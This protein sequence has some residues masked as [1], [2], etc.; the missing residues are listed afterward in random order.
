ME[1]AENVGEGVVSVLG[2]DDSHFQDVLDGMTEE[3]MN[4]A[5]AVHAERQEE[6]RQAGLLPR[7]DENESPDIENANAKPVISISRSENE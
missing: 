5:I 3:E 7:N 2:L 4:R 1:I 6:Y